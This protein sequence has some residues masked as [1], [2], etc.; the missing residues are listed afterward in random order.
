[1][2]KVY[3]SRENMARFK[4]LRFVKEPG[5]AWAFWK[6]M[7]AHYGVDL[8]GNERSVVVAERDKDLPY[9][10]R[11]SY[12]PRRL[13]LMARLELQKLETEAHSRIIT[14]AR[15]EKGL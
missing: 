10:F 11:F 12:S 7:A 15:I 3:L 13:P 5:E 6:D 8:M 4:G 1:M 2:K 9:L 14:W